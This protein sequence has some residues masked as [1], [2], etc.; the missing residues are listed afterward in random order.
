MSV[1]K[2]MSYKWLKRKHGEMDM[3]D[4]NESQ[5]LTCTVEENTYEAE[6]VFHNTLM[7]LTDHSDNGDTLWSQVG[8]EL[9]RFSIY[10]FGLITG[11]KCVGSTHLPPMAEPKLIRRYFPTVRGVSRENLELQMS[12]AKFDNDVIKLSLLYIIFC[13]PLSNANSVKIDSNFFELADNLDEFNEFPWGVLS[14]EVTRAAICATVDNRT[15]SKR[16]PLK[17]SRQLHYSIAGFPHALLVWAYES[18]PTMAAKFTT[19]YEEAIPHMLSWITA[20]NVKF[21]EVMWAFT[22]VGENQPKC[23]GIMPIEEELKDPWVAQLFLKNP[24]AVPQLL[25]KPSVAR[26]SSGTNSEWQEFKEEIRGQVDSINKSLRVLKKDQNKSNKLLRRVLKM[27]TDNM[28]QQGQGKAQ[29]GTPVTSRQPMD[30]PTNESDALKT[31]SDDNATGMQDEVL[32]DSSIGAAADIGVQAAMEFLTGETVIVSHQHVEEESNKEKLEATLEGNV[33]E[34]MVQSDPLDK[35]KEESMPHPEKEKKR[36]KIIRS[37]VDRMLYSLQAQPRRPAPVPKKKRARLSRLGQWPTGSRTEVG[38]PAREPSQSIFALPPSLV[39]EPPA[40]MLKEFREWINKWALKKTP[41]GKQPPRYNAKHDPLDKPH[42]LR[43]MEVEKKRWYYELVTS[44]VWLWDEH[45]DVAFY[46]L[47]KKIKQYPN[48][49]QRKVTTVDTFFSSKIA[50]TWP[51]YQSSPDKFD[52]GTL[53]LVVLKHWVLVKLELTDWTME[54][55]DSVEH[56]GPHNKKVREGVEGLSM[57]IPLLA[58]QI[59]LFEFKPRE[60]PRMHPI[61]VTILKDIPKQGNGREGCQV[62][63]NSWTDATVSRV[64]SM[65]LVGSCEAEACKSL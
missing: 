6:E 7:R 13:I 29:S 48:L 10:E 14:W 2:Q 19:N 20:D 64:A 5:K 55:Y 24:K 58:A 61:P 32:I 49:E 37:S 18:I 47:R 41:P 9:G 52:W 33:G 59:G 38:S 34:G 22:A 12:N 36:I 31:T 8:E 42:D 43:I 40:L 3:H 62:L 39:D 1:N 51:V 17:K 57:F 11:M 35:I 53:N 50:A 54:V 56:E 26:S 4:S 45:I 30:V 65:L 25:L 21:D 44:P 63:G 27:L 15:S 23:V 60:P 46:Y 28:S 16:K